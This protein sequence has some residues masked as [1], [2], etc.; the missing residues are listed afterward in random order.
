[1]GPDMP[2]R[3]VIRVYLPK[4]MRAVPFFMSALLF[5]SGFFAIFSAIPFQVL[6]LGKRW[7][8]LCFA[9]VLNTIWVGVLGG[10]GSL[11]LYL[12]FSIVPGIVL[13]PRLISSRSMT[14]AW[15]ETWM[16][17]MIA[18]GLIW[19]LYAIR[20]HIPIIDGVATSLQAAVDQV[21]G[22]MG[23][24]ALEALQGEMDLVDWKKAVIRELPSSFLLFGLIQ[25]WVSLA[26][27]VRANPAGT[28]WK[29]GVGPEKAR[30]WKSPDFLIW[31]LILLGGLSLYPLPGWEVWIDNLLR[32]FLGIYGVQGTVVL[33][34]FMDSWGI[35]GMY[36]GLI[37][38]SAL[39]FMLPLVIAV[40]VFDLWFDF[41]K[42]LRQST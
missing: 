13:I 35:R 6:M 34:S 10:L 37:Y 26:L 29:M 16:G 32:I 11:P 30:E 42:N 3:R 19:S 4:W 20:N 41:R 9:L 36:R 33:A 7:K 14:R 8:S 24:E 28:L 40:G 18:A 17:M 39:L 23:T 38:L 27:L 31:G 25:V 2:K 22:A 15:L 12:V 5:L 21:A 1:M